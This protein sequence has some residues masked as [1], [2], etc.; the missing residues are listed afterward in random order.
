MFFAVDLVSIFYTSNF[1][2][3]LHLQFFLRFLSYIDVN[4]WMSYECS[5]QGRTF[6]T[7][8]LGPMYQVA[9]VAPEIA[10]KNS[11]AVQRNFLSLKF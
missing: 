3:L 1:K 10:T 9:K 6:I 2:V 8:L 7:H 4:E 11:S 5:A